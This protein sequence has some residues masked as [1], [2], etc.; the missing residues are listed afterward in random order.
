LELRAFDKVAWR[1]LDE[2]ARRDPGALACRNLDELA[3]R[4][5]DEPGFDDAR[6]M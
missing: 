3:R 2:L 4:D 5:F 6:A 1:N